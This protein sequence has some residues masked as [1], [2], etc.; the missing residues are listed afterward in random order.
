MLRGTDRRLSMIYICSIG[1][2]VIIC[3]S[4]SYLTIFISLL[5]I[6]ANGFLF[7]TTRRALRSTIESERRYRRLID[8]SPDAIAV[9]QGGIIV[10]AN[11][12]CLGLMG[13][14]HTSQLIGQPVMKFVPPHLAEVVAK[15]AKSAIKETEVGTMDE[16]FVRPDGSVIDVEV[17]AIGIPYNGRPAVLIICRDIGLRKEAERKMTE[18]N[19]LL[20][21]LSRLD[22]LTSISN[23]RA[24]DEQILISWNAASVDNGHLSLV[25]LDVDSFKD[26]NDHYG[27]QA[28]DACLQTIAKLVEGVA[29]EA[30][31]TAYRYG[32]EEFAVLL[33][34]YDRN[35]GKSVADRIRKAVEECGIPHE[36]AAEGAIVTISVGVGTRQQSSDASLEQWVQ[37]TDQALYLAKKQGRNSTIEAPLY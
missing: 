29:N 7:R 20:E 32:G 13:I 5:A 31:G 6:L 4:N 8:S 17:T 10:F 28:G 33:P 12:A 14:E 1:L 2:I 36:G 22:G 21:K 25:L 30:G 15:R 9:H 37:A 18:A 23:R 3:V 19:A 24:F 34:G 35:A 16:Q 27:H 11:P 26:Y